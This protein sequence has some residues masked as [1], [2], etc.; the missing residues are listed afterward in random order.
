[1]SRLDA[2]VEPLEGLDDAAIIHL[3]G[4]LDQPTLGQFQSELQAAQDQGQVFVILDLSGVT[5]ANSTTLGALVN[6]ADA[7]RDAGGEL[8][9]LKPQPKVDLVIDMLGL[10]SLFKI[11]ASQAEATQYVHSLVSP[12]A[13]AQGQAQAAGAAEAAEPSAAAFPVR[14]NC[15][16]CDIV[17]EF[18]QASHYRCPRCSAVYR[19]DAAG[20]IAGG[21]PRGRPPI[22]MSLTCD[23]ASL[24]AFR[25]FVGALPAWAG[26]SNE[27]RDQLEQAIGEICETIRQKAYEGD[28]Q[29]ALNVLILRRDD[30]LSLRMADHGKPL[31]P[32]DFPRAANFMTEFEHRPHP[33]RGNVLKMTRKAG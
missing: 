32:E 29:G 27:E 30:G 9:L 24:D 18:P 7:F 22:E 12:G 31:S 15:I 19:V 6:Q 1:M 23:T 33:T 17:L 28:D 10:T 4:V 25:T 5:Y 3:N 26:Y 16:G 14:A 13:A 11:F 21:K 8:V 2:L 20:K